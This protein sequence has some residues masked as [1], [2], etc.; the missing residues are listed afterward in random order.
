MIKGLLKNIRNTDVLTRNAATRMQK[1]VK[2]ILR[3]TKKKPVLAVY[4]ITT[5]GRIVTMKADKSFSEAKSCDSCI[6][7]AEKWFHLS[8]DSNNKGVH[9]DHNCAGWQ[10]GSDC[11][12]K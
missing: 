3:K 12:G 9:K 7:G 8:N 4:S 1:C 6:C 2:S 11:N 5:L 10:Y